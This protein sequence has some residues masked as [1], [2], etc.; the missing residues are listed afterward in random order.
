M[1]TFPPRLILPVNK[2]IAR[3]PEPDMI[4]IVEGQLAGGHEGQ[5]PL[6][7]S[8]SAPSAVGGGVEP[9]GP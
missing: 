5:S 1:G 8:P 3:G 6:A 7:Q 2:S 9:Y 4:C